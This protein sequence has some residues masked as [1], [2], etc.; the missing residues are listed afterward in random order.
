[1]RAARSAWA[2]A[3]YMEGAGLGRCCN[4]GQ[5]LSSR[6]QI[7][8]HPVP[9]PSPKNWH[10]AVIDRTA[11]A[12]GMVAEAFRRAL[13]QV[14]PPPANT[15]VDAFHAYFTGVFR[16]LGSSF[17]PYLSAAFG[18]TGFLPPLGNSCP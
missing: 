3:G 13:S 9:S 18:K 11:C 1:M 17:S 14:F 10:V 4:Q 8:V 5:S 7:V 15:P 6:G 12:E 2:P 16:S